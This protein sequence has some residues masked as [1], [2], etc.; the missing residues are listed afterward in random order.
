VVVHVEVE[1]NHR[2]EVER[3]DTAHDDRA[4]RVGEEVDRVVVG[5]ELREAREDRGRLRIVQCTSSAITP[6]CVRRNVC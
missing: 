3:A 2:F 6:D 1:V 4:Q 5:E